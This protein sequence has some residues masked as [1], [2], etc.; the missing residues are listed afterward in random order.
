MVSPLHHL[1]HRVNKGR[2]K[3]SNHLRGAKEGK[4]AL[5]GI[6]RKVT[7]NRPQAHVHEIGQLVPG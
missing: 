3:E 7:M 4:K 1:I 5:S 6:R 2:K